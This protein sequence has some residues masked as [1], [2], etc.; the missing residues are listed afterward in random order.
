MNASYS[1]TM[2]QYVAMTPGEGPLPGSLKAEMTTNTAD[3]GAGRVFSAKPV[4]TM[5]GETYT[6]DVKF[7]TEVTH[8]PAGTKL[9]AGGGDAGKSLQALLTAMK[10][11]DFKAIQA[12]VTAKRVE[13]FS[14][15]DDAVQTLGM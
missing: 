8:G 13:S 10:K 3:R 12:G 7:S 1:Q 5:D 15:V 11:K 2:T 6:V 9:P 14:D 4:K